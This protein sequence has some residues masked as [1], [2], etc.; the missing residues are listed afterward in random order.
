MGFWGIREDA[1]ILPP[2]VFRHF[3][4][5][6]QSEPLA[7]I[8][9]T[10]CALLLLPVP[11]FC[12]GA[13]VRACAS[14]TVERAK[15][16]PKLTPNMRRKGTALPRVDKVCVIIK[17]QQW[18]ASAPGTPCKSNRHSH[19]T[20]ERAERLIAEGKMEYVPGQQEHVTPKGA[21]VRQCWI[22]VVRFVTQRRWKKRMSVGA[23]PPVAT[24]Q[25]VG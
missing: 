13:L 12:R 8:K 24:M 11:R 20:R 7:S 16:R 6:T 3:R 25:L 2:F 1:Q 17:G 9:R 23:G 14:P 19:M 21:E 22:P 4:G 5:L 10:H 15:R 18:E